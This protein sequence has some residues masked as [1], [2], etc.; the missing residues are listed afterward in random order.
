[1][2]GTISVLRWLAL[3]SDL[4]SKVCFFRLR[5][6]TLL[7]LSVFYWRRE[8]QTSA[9]S[10]EVAPADTARRG[11]SFHKTI[12]HLTVAAAGFAMSQAGLHRREVF[13]GINHDLWSRDL[14]GNSASAAFPNA[15][16]MA[17]SAAV[18]VVTEEIC[19]SHTAS[20]AGHIADGASAGYSGAR[21]RNGTAGVAAAAAVLIVTDEE[22][23]VANI[24]PL[25]HS[26]PREQGG[27]LGTII[28]LE[29]IPRSIAC[30]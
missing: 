29:S 18:V 9:W 17:A 2:S 13:A 24:P 1:M 12:E 26:C 23:R 27:H 10:R 20:Q 30:A 19:R 25:H 11:A 15:A 7:Q 8:K 21:L 3:N 28:R 16:A 22:P 4:F 5:T 14:L 6:I